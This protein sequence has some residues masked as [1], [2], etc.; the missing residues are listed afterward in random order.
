MNFS[1]CARRCGDHCS[2]P[3]P[4]RCAILGECCGAPRP[5][6]FG[7]GV[8]VVG[9][10]HPALRRAGYCAGPTHGGVWCQ[11]GVLAGESWFVDWCNKRVCPSG[12]ILEL[13]LQFKAGL[14]LAAQDRGVESM[15]ENVRTALHEIRHQVEVVHGLGGQLQGVVASGEETTSADRKRWHREVGTLRALVRGTRLQA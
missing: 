4:P 14:D 7:A 6:L 3:S 13:L 15:A 5:F 9:P 2:P 8:S 11:G 12:D 1:I 10:I